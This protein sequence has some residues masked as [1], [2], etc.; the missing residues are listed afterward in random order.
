VDLLVS[1]LGG[2]ECN[3]GMEFINQNNVL[4]E[5]QNRL[6]RIP[7]KSGIVKVKAHEMPC[8]GGPTIHFMLGKT[9][10]RECVGGYDMLCVMRVLDEYEP[11]E[12]TKLVTSTKC[13]KRILE[14]FPDVMPE[15]L[16][17]DMPP[18]RRVDHAIEVVPEVAPPAKAPYRM[19]HEELKELKVQLEE[20]LAKGYIKPS[21]SPYGAPILFVHKKDGTLRMCVDYRA[22][23][24]AT[25]KKRYP[26]PQIDDL[27]DCLSGAKV[28]S[29]ID[30]R[31]GYY[32]IRIAEGDEEKI[33][34]RTRYGSYEFLVMPFGLTNAPATFCILM[35]DI[36]QEW[37]DDFV[38]VYI[39]NI[40]IYSGSLEEHAKHLRKVFQRIREN[41]L[42]A[43]L[44]KCEFGVTE[45]DFL[46]HRITQKGLKMDDHKVRA[47]VDSEPPKSV[48]A[49]RS[50]LGLASYYRKFIKNFAKI[51]VPLT[52]L[53]KKSAVTYKWE[54]TCDEAFETLKGILGKAPVLKLPDFDKDF[55]IHS[56]ASNF[57]IGGVLMQEGRP[58]AFES[59]K[60]SETE[61]RW[62]TH[63]KEM[64][65]V[66][67]CLKTWGH[68]ISSKD[69]VV[70]TDNVTLKYFATQPKL[71][72]K[73]VR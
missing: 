12:A 29:R 15:E 62:P 18:R 2:M 72:S 49:L 36:F 32:Q 69:V 55:E 54:E 22:F 7:S 45:V 17:E 14:E 35:N 33:V 65:V 13:I 50:F 20:L 43:K 27:F 4:I 53:L 71:S 30:L 63:E 6:L 66:I 28:F 64:W 73:Q 47:I 42:Y 51:A 67:H 60:L 52:N 9:W 3:L 11:K 37:L 48:P 23:N 41:K 24:K 21:K 38:V 40:S 68:Y 31:S 16:S 61:R 58:V 57:A 70:W 5:G 56:N 59:K 10:E 1:S 19:S 44:E 39:D 25:V 46:G 8:V 34:F 26:L